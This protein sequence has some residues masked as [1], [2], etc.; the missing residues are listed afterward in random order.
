[1]V[2]NSKETDRKKIRLRPE[3][4]DR[5]DGI[6]TAS[7]RMVSMTSLVNRAMELCIEAF[8]AASRSANSSGAFLATDFDE[9]V[10]SIRVTFQPGSTIANRTGLAIESPN[11]GEISGERK[12]WV[13]KLLRVLQSENAEAIQGAIHGIE[14]GLESINANPDVPAAKAVRDKA[15]APSKAARMRRKK[16]GR[17]S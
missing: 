2:T 5:I 11:L 3:L 9:A 17:A 1:M 16:P 4:Y 10:S 12:E 13:L 15:E 7:H 14:F 6:Y 8:E